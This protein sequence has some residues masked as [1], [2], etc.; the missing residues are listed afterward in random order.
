MAGKH[1]ARPPTSDSP[2]AAVRGGSV[3]VSA[4]VC[5]RPCSQQQQGA[6]EGLR[7]G[8]LPGPGGSVTPSTW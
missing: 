7:G 2:S 1:G 6:N 8:S 3:P 5:G 4:L